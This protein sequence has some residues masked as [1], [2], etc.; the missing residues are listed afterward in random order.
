[1]SALVVHV[2]MA[3]AVWMVWTNIYVLVFL[4]LLGPIVKPVSIETHN[5]DKA[6]LSD[7]LNVKLLD[8]CDKQL[9][10]RVSFKVQVQK[11]SICAKF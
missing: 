11:G 1:M 10:T 6:G 4:G 8:T 5:Q 3:V 9:Q 7:T 2:E